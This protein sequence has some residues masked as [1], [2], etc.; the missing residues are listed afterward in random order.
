LE[1][2]AGEVEALIPADWDVRPISAARYPQEG[3]VAS[4]QLSKW[5][6]GAGVVRGM[7]AFWV[8]ITRLRIPSDYY[9]LVARGPAVSSLAGNKNWQPT[10]EQVLAGHP[11][12]FPGWNH[13]PAV[14]GLPA[15]AH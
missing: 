11:P 4:P 1:V 5:E 13:P 12:E 14:N 7:E 15:K 9:Y 6:R 10:G 2:Q 8:D 3:F